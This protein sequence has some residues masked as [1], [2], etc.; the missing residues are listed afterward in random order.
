MR[1]WLFDG[2]DITGPF[3]PKE[4]A[5]RADFSAASMLAPETQSDDQNAWNRA[6]SFPHF[7][8]NE[9]TGELTLAD[10][11]S[12]EPELALPAEEPE[13]KKPETAPPLPLKKPEAQTPIPLTKPITLA[14]ETEEFLSLPAHRETA[15]VTSNLPTDVQS[16]VESVQEKAE[17]QP[18]VSQETS[19]TETL[20]QPTK[21]PP[22]QTETLT[23]Q[24]IG[25]R[26]V[27]R[28][29][30]PSTPEIDDF[31]RSQKE[32]HR[33]GHHKAVLMLWILFILLLPGLVALAVHKTHP[34]KSA[35]AKKKVV[36]PT[37]EKPM[38]QKSVVQ[39]VPVEPVLP[40]PEP[41][42]PAPP[43]TIPPEK[44]TLS[45][46]AIETVKNYQL[47]A[48]R[49][50]VESYFK[51]IYKTQLGNGGYVETWSAEPLHKSIYIV[52]YRLTKTRTEPVVYVFQ[53]DVS[54]GK[55]IGALNNV[56]LDLIGKI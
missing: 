15:D 52:K 9:E 33:P 37:E 51:R 16:A 20:P 28:P 7:Q 43:P 40:V 47:S 35:S 41:E 24:P 46:K 54:K 38:A 17:S 5:A 2:N 29:H 48:N 11:V 27:L 36:V 3:S 44:P 30:L 42:P 50:T 39:I 14:E 56:T 21:E 1:Y 31:L 55:V 34:A 13:V 8:F 49:G 12:P 25:E 32:S 45:D 18:A 26:R 23:P 6:S 22:D 19:L 4:L 10:E 53:T